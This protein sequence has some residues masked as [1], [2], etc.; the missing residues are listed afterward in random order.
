MQESRS[1]SKFLSEWPAESDPSLAL[2]RNASQLRSL[3]VGRTQQ[4]R[5]KFGD[6]GA[7][8]TAG[9]QVWACSLAKAMLHRMRTLHMKEEPTL[10]R[11]A[12]GGISWCALNHT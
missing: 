12:H 10:V 4:E 9:Q 3:S 8:A 7:A 5:R 11:V 1:L 6:A 2:A